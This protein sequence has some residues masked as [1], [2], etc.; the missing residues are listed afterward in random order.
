M[1]KYEIVVGNIGSVGVYNNPV[2]AN[3]VYWQYVR[4]SKETNGRASGENVVLFKDDEI[5]K[6]YFGSKDKGEI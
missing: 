6:E 2:Q 4:T 1:A 3:A 5:S